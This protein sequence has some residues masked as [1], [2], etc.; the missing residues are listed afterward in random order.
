[1]FNNTICCKVIL[2]GTSC[3]RC[4]VELG[5]WHIQKCLNSLRLLVSMII[6]LDPK[7]LSIENGMVLPC[8]LI[9]HVVFK[10]LIIA[11]AYDHMKKGEGFYHIV[12]M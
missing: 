9:Y 7:N 10:L 3:H 8:G 12:R 4:L 2:V 5:P 1:M 6:S 11:S